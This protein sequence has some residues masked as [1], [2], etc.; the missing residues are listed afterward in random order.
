MY[1]LLLFFYHVLSLIGHCQPTG[2]NDTSYQY[3]YLKYNLHFLKD[4]TVKLR[5]P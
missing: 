1:Q 5:K 3:N 4:V 2:E